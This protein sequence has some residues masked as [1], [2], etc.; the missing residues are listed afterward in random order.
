M[1]DVFPERWVMCRPFLGGINEVC[2]AHD[3]DRI[4]CEET[5]DGT[6]E[7]CKHSYR[8]E[9]CENWEGIVFL[10]S[11]RSKIASKH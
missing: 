5:D 3:H 10:D 8:T 2:S 11:D 6:G 7:M 1:Y 9:M 4:A